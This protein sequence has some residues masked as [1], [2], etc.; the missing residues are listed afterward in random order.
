MQNFS[1]EG[2][3]PSPQSPPP[4]GRRTPLPHTLP[5][6]RL[7]LNPSY[8]EIL[9][10]LLI[11][12]DLRKRMSSSNTKP[13]VVCSRHG[14]HLEI[15]YDVITAPRLARFERNLGTWFRIARKLQL[16]PCEIIPLYLV[17]VNRSPDI[18]STVWHR[19]FSRLL[20]TSFSRSTRSMDH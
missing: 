14:R 7:D 20:R 2:A 8:S 15:V 16:S 5:P 17:Q 13:E 18:H 12:V 9:P 6:R 10:T 19:R 3:Q 4:L 11:E 1:G